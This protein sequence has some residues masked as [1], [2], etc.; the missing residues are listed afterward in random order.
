MF[1]NLLPKSYW[2]M[3]NCKT[4]Q[5]KEDISKI[6]VTIRENYI[7][8]P[9]N[10]LNTEDEQHTPDI[11]DELQEDHIVIIN[12]V[13]EANEVDKKNV[14]YGRMKLVDLKSLARERGLYVTGN[15]A[16]YVAALSSM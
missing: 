3:D 4:F 2:E 1:I 9:M 5:H 15:K 13:I 6:D 11:C 12:N 10:V 16:Q 8:T 14:E 7:E